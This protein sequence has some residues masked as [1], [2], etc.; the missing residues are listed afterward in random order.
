MNTQYN[1][2]NN[3]AEL[4][5]LEND[6]DLEFIYKCIATIIY[7]FVVYMVYYH[8]MLIAKLIVLVTVTSFILY[9]MVALFKILDN[10]HIN[11]NAAIQ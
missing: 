1:R 2:E 10:I 6:A 5:Y 4:H 8:Y 9:H 11:M 3:E 7:I